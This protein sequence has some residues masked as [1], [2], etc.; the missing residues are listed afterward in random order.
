MRL[1]LGL[2]FFAHVSAFSQEY[3]VTYYS[4]KEGLAN[5]GVTAICQDKKGNLWFATFGGGVSQ[6]NGNSFRNFGFEQG[7]TELL[8][9]TVAEDSKGRLFAGTSGGGVFVIENDSARPF[10]N[11]QLPD[12][13]FM[14]H[15]AENGIIWLGT[16]EGVFTIDEKDSVTNFTTAHNMLAGPITHINSDA[17][18]NV[19]F[20]YDEFIGLFCY[21]GTE[22]IQ[23][24]AANGLTD[25]R[26][27]NTFHDS[28]ENTWVAA[29]DGLYKISK[30]STNAVKINAAGIPDYYLFDFAEPVKGILAIGTQADGILFYDVS[31]NRVIRKIGL[32]NGL[33]GAIVFRVFADYENNLWVSNWG[34]GIACFNFS[35]FT[36]YAEGNGLNARIINHLF[37]VENGFLVSTSQG[38]F[39]FQGNA[40]SPLLP[41]KITGGISCTYKAGET[42]FCARER[43]L[44]VY[45]NG[46]VKTFEQPWNL[47][48]RAIIADRQG[49]V[50]TASRSGGIAYFDG[51]QFVPVQ[52]TAIA[53]IG[54]YYTAICDSK[55]NLWFGSWG[56]GLVCFDGKKWF[57]LTTADGLPSDKI[58]ALT[59]DKNG[60]MVVGTAGGGIAI[61][62]NE[63]FHIIQVSDGLASNSVYSLSTDADNTIWAGFSGSISHIIMPGY[64]VIN[65]STEAGFEGDCLYNSILADSNSVWF[66]TNNFLWRY[67]DADVIPRKLSLRIYLEEVWANTRSI[68]R[69][70]QPDLA[71]TENKITFK[72]SNTQIYDNASVKYVYRLIGIDSAFSSPSTQDEITFHELAPG[73]YTFEAKAC[74]DGTCSESPVL[75]PFTISP[76]FWK[77]WW[78]ISLTVILSVVLIWIFVRY[79]EYK[80]VMRQQELEQTV[81]ERTI[82][83]REQKKIVEEKNKEIIDSISYAK[84]LQDAIL[85]PLKL[86]REYL[87]ESFILYKPK[88]IVAGDFYW[89]ESFAEASDSKRPFAGASDSKH[90]FAGASDSKHPFAGASDSKRPFAGASDSKHPFAGAS[91]SKRPFAGASD[92]KHPFAGASDSGEANSTGNSDSRELILFAAADCTGHGVPGAMVSV[93]CNN[94]LNRAI[95]EYGIT[96]PGKILDKTRELV[97][98]EFE[99]SSDEVKDGMDISLCSLSLSTR[100][101]QWAGANNPLWLIRNGTQEICEIKADKQPIGKYSDP[102]PFTTHT[103]KLEKG[104]T[105]YIFTDG[106]QDQFGG[107]KGKK[108][109]ASKLKEA[110]LAIQ[111]ESMDKQCRLLDQT[112]ELWRGSL[113]QIDDVCLI[114]VRL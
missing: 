86:V 54:F 84:R 52:D 60:N 50:Y 8:T 20:A 68:S 32:Q 75:F 28:A 2:V 103:L 64:K 69:L 93:V 11:E 89:F 47:N 99:K 45:K 67:S 77:T 6:Y 79:R 5:S 104:D 91:D 88:D 65:Y 19:W 12:E 112:F 1:I 33:K 92:S 42:F 71:Y 78:F 14:I 113:E 10:R 53:S 3:P 16:N 39:S 38:L 94:S 27:N 107:D 9:R 22:L 96:D 24:N 23:F 61:R 95:R 109:K 102:L 111:S 73:S 72:F 13:V 7:L 63:G 55:G 26:I 48:V 51:E 58:T 100:T 105:L 15:V 29:Y 21:T 31:T 97:I 41:G 49:T 25:G 85:P 114:G 74:L 44:L 106:F 80:L 70:V 56:A 46:A 40:F 17:A 34:E 62:T 43:D 57:R 108:F 36:K 66:G 90:P 81:A 30:G 76:P 82:E 98:R 59:E 101:L 37:K 18:G 110:L 83:I 35:G 87:N 4:S